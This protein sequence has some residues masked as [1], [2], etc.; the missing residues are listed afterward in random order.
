[1]DNLTVICGNSRTKNVAIAVFIRRMS[2]RYTY[3]STGVSAKVTVNKLFDPTLNVDNVHKQ[4][5]SHIVLTKN[6]TTQV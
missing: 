2:G 3:F 6:N 4:L 5:N 1:M